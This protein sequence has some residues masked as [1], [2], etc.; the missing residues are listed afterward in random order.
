[1]ETVVRSFL[2]LVKLTGRVDANLILQIDLQQ[3]EQQ[4][5]LSQCVFFWH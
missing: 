2:V 5:Q 4:Q 1:M 3:G